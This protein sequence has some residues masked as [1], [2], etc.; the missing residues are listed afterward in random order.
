VEAELEAGSRL[1]LEE[2][3]ALALDER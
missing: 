2:A 3:V 1:T